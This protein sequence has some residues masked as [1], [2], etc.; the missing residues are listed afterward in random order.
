MLSYG[1]QS[2]D[3]PRVPHRTPLCDTFETAQSFGRIK[4]DNAQGQTNT[5][6]VVYN[7]Y[8]CAAAAQLKSPK[9]HLKPRPM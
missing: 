1:A 4:D 6:S 3:R 2:R 8:I 7:S 9:F 5:F